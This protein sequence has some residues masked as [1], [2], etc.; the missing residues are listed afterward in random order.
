MVN[1]PPTRFFDLCSIEES[2]TKE[3][4]ENEKEKTDKYE[5]YSS[6]FNN[7]TVRSYMPQLETRLRKNDIIFDKINFNNGF[8][9]L[10][11]KTLKPRIRRVDYVTAYIKS[12]YKPSTTKQRKKVMILV[13][14]IYPKKADR[15]ILKRLIEKLLL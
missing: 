1:P 6:I 2:F 5:R 3:L 7:V 10:T 15:N 14:K 8:Y 11:T 12:D 4:T 13:S 9:D